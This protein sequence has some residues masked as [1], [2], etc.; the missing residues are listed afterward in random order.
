MGSFRVAFKEWQRPI[1]P[2]L[3]PPLSQMLLL[4]RFLDAFKL[5][6]IEF[7]DFMRIEAGFT[8][9]Q[10]EGFVKVRLAIRQQ[11][12]PPP[13][14][15]TLTMIEHAAKSVLLP[16]GSPNDHDMNV[17][18]ILNYCP[19]EIKATQFFKDRY[20]KNYDLYVI[21]WRNVRRTHKFGSRIELSVFTKQLWEVIHTCKRRQKKRKQQ[22]QKKRGEEEE[23][24]IVM[25]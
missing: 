3:S 15:V 9:A 14:I 19:S 22:Q 23:E 17:L 24:S 16:G 20:P 25:I 13:S 12:K 8:D 11:Q 6:S 21:A 2:I 5:E 4:E 18:H 1:H 7:I 10:I